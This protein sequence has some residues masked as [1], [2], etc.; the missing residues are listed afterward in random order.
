MY[1]KKNFNLELKIGVV[2]PC[3]KVKEHI[4]QVIELIPCFIDHIYIV[5]DCCPQG[6]GTHVHLNQ[7]N[8]ENKISIIDWNDFFVANCQC[9]SSHHG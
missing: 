6:S 4:L 7:K 1:I 2:I 9:S 3:F 8:N 5:D